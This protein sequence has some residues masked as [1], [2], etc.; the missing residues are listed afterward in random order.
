MAIRNT[1]DIIELNDLE[2]DLIS[3]SLEMSTVLDKLDINFK[4]DIRYTTF[5]TLSSIIRSIKLYFIIRKDNLSRDQWWDDTFVSKYPT[6]LTWNSVNTSNN[7]EITKDF[8]SFIN[9]AFYMSFFSMTERTLRIIHDAIICNQHT[10]IINT[11]EIKKV[12]KNIS[13]KITFSNDQLKAFELLRTIRNTNHN[14]GFYTGPNK[15]INYR[16]MII[17]LRKNQTPNFVNSMNLLIQNLIPDIV[18]I[19]YQCLKETK[20][21][22]DEMT[23]LFLNEYNAISIKSPT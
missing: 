22:K 20:T 9:V 17:N 6:L 19:L 3:K 12:F 16:N 4:R 15:I 21:I 18:S 13:A 2:K 8:D 7:M 5:N 10:E 14:N 23:D 11:D 1:I